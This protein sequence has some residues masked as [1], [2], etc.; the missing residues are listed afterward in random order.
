MLSSP[1]LAPLSSH[2]RR[3]ARGSGVR[4]L[5]LTALLTAGGAASATAPAVAQ[6][7]QVWV[8]PANDSL[9][10]WAADA[11]AR[12]HA[13][14]GDS[15]SDDNYRA[16]DLVGQMSRRLLRSLGP[17]HLV[18][19]HDIKPLLDSLGLDTDVAT[20]PSQASFALVMVRNPYQFSVY[21]V[22]FLYWWYRNQDLR[23]Q[24]VVFRG[25]KE[26]T[27]RVWWTGHP[28][29]PYE[30]AVVD[31]ERGNGPARFTLMRLNSL[32]TSWA[33]AHSDE[34]DPILGDPGEAVFA[35]LDHDGRPELVQWAIAKTD[36]LFVPCSDCPRL[37]IEKTY[38][39]RQE[40][41]TLHESRMMPS[42]YA[43]FVTFVR[44]LLDN[45]RLEAARLVSD[46]S[47]VTKSLAEGWG[48]S[49]KP[50][51][52][53]IEYGEQDERW[54]RWLAMRFEGPQGVRRYIVHFGLRDGRWIIEQWVV[55]QPVQR[56]PLPSPAHGAR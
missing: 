30:W 20:D 3:R 21:S 13:N 44:L 11:R 27:I 17:R 49:R 35:D 14:R 42:P 43:T 52:W 22:G 55:P 46:A 2:R 45:H 56:K 39:E 26:P 25:G 19:A 7:I 23:M 54:P 16:Y 28:E 9:T 33:L 32:G 18:L 41:F 36:S 15:V 48:V 12:F 53:R 6:S 40:G 50:G 24:G 34:E 51:T 10:T 29:G 38:V 5:V 8:P 37:M 47:L 31:H 4:T 1:L